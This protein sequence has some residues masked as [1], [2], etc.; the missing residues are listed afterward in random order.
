MASDSHAVPFS[1][2]R[3]LRVAGLFAAAGLSLSV[4]KLATGLAISCPWRSLT[5]TLCP[6]C[7]GTTMG[8]RLL[9]G[10]FAGAWASNP[11]ALVLLGLGGV[12]AIVWTVEVAGGP[13][14]RPPAA[15]RSSAL[16]WSLL[17]VTA[18]AFMIVRNL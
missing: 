11:F 12:A 15:L 16:W 3:A 13:A 10:D 8:T 6:L 1:A 5:G 18:L 4:V 9:V 14:L 17:G 2:A 7:G